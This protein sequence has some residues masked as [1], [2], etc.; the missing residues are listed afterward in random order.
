MCNF[1]RAHYEDNYYYVILN[2]A[3]G[4]GDVVLRFLFFSSGSHEYHSV[5]H[6]HL[7]NFSRGH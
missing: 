1:G 3:S 5:E 2:W 6:N 4:S 7:S